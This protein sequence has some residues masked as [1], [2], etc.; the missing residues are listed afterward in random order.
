MRAERPKGNIERVSFW[1]QRINCGWCGRQDDICGPKD[2][3][4]TAKR[5]RLAARG[6]GYRGSSRHG[7]LC[8]GCHKAK[9]WSWEEQTSIYVTCSGCQQGVVAALDAGSARPALIELGW[10]YTKDREYPHGRW[11]CGGCAKRLGAVDALGG[12]LLPIA[13]LEALAA[14]A[15]YSV[16]PRA[17]GVLIRQAVA[18]GQ[19]GGITASRQRIISPATWAVIAE[20]AESQRD[21]DEALGRL[22]ARTPWTTRS[23]AEPTVR[24]GVLTIEN[25]GILADGADGAFY[26]PGGS[27]WTDDSDDF[28][29]EPE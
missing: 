24:R 10:V 4:L 5:A 25:G 14:D 16:M 28:F 18:M 13:A 29:A 11:L 23:T 1:Q 9:P 22:L 15:R 7:W 12:A 2:L 17:Q 6:A 26:V 27:I 3:L 20:A 8:G 21:V 19:R